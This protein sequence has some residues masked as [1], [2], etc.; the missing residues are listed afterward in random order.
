MLAERHNGILLSMLISV[1]L[2]SEI[3]IP[4]C[5]HLKVSSSMNVYEGVYLGDDH[6]DEDVCEKSSAGDSC[7]KAIR[8]GFQKV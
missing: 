8:S 3:Q 6:P 2:Y 1:T 4:D 7:S 5:T